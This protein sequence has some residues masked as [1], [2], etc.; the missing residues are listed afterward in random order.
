[1]MNFNFFKLYK[2]TIFFSQ[3]FLHCLY[4]LWLGPF[5][6]HIWNTPAATHLMP[7]MPLLT[8]WNL[9]P[10]S[11]PTVI[12]PWPTTSKIHKLYLITE[13]AFNLYLGFRGEQ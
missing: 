4:T 11:E 1:M 3:G 2:I 5:W 9:T 8:L 6:L 10:L 7:T 12:S 13:A